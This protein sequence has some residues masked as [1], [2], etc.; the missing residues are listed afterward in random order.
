MS[1]SK[2]VKLPKSTYAVVSFGFNEQ[3]EKLDVELV[4]SSWLYLNED[5]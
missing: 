5:N 1:V 4:L 3:T 2:P